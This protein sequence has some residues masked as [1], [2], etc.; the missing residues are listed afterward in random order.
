MHRVDLVDTLHDGPRFCRRDQSHLHMD[1]PDDQHTVLSL[2]LTS[3]VSLPLLASMWRAS[4]APPNVP[5]IPEL[6]VLVDRSVEYGECRRW[7]KKNRNVCT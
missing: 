6:D 7:T 2:N 5:S 4:S 3:P 1:P